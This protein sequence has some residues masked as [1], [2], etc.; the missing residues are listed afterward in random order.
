M[1]FAAAWPSALRLK[2]LRPRPS[3]LLAGALGGAW[4]VAQPRTADLAAQVY[5]AD[6]FVR[7]GFS[8]W[9]NGWFA[10]HQLLGYSLV[11]PALGSVFGLRAVGLASVAVS[12]LC[13][14]SL[15]TRLRP[16]TGPLPAAWFAAAA[17][18]DLF[19]GRLTFALGT[20]VALVALVALTR[21]RTVAGS[22][23]CAL[24]AVTSPVVALFLGLILAAAWGCL[25]R[26]KLAVAGTAL[27]TTVIV[28]ALWFADGGVQP[29]DLTTAL[30]G[31]AMT[32]AVWLL[33]DPSER[34]L[35]RAVG[36]YAIAS[37]AAFAVPTPMGS[38][39]ARLGV[40]A[41]GPVLLCA[42]RRPGA[43]AVLACSCALAI[44]LL[45]GPVAETIKASQSDAADAAYFA[46]LIGE[47][48]ALHI[49]DHRVE[50]VPTSTRWESVYVAL[51]FP[52]AR[53]WETQLDRR[54]NALFYDQAIAPSAYRRWLD[55]T[56]VA[57]V[58][59][60]DSTPQRWGAAE[61]ALLRTPPT[62]LKP[63]WHSRHWRVFAVSK[64]QPIVHGAGLVDL[65]PS[66]MSVRFAR[67]GT[68]T[69][70]V[71]YTSYWRA[72]AGACV[73]SG[74]AGTTRITAYAPGVVAVT[75]PWRPSAVVAD[76]DACPPVTA[77]TSNG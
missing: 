5:R 11:S 63:V 36:L 6:L 56:S 13:V 62:Y 33:L 61:A 20:A 43:G 35:R 42:R 34:F 45:W 69:L 54:Y 52:I 44:S 23:L 4:A 19:I 1:T 60:S 65:D 3:L 40:L 21:G 46:P 24:C 38:N 41:L 27:A 17:V 76:R 50:I 16:G 72:T 10:G 14:E 49:G 68:A 18:G 59:L 12:V 37:V 31:T 58:A 8:V 48:R 32:V 66:G 73:R 28:N 71:H 47:L 30:A 15:V 77:Q 7:S 57:Y 22:L 64:P 2:A 53:G 9:D 29:D 67:P 51:D 70:A 74:P 25:P 75:A 26:R 39:V 55:R